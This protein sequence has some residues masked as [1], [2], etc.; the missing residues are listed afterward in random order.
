[1]DMLALSDFLLQ[2]AQRHLLT[3]LRK[4]SRCN[5]ADKCG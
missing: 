4:T 5:E 2:S 1:M 3:G